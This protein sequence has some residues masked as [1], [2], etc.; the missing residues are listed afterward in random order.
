MTIKT[1]MY[2]FV[3]SQD[4]LLNSSCTHKEHSSKNHSQQSSHFTQN[5]SEILKHRVAK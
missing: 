1:N 2:K 5:P 3:A 4:Y